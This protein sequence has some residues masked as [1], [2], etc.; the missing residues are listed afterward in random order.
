MRLTPADVHN[1]AFKKPSIGKRGYDEDEVDAF[2]DLVEAE[3]SRLIEE[4]NELTQR[5]AA[6]QA[7]G[8]AAGAPA[9]QAPYQQPEAV[10]QY[11]EQAPVEAE[12]DH[13]AA[14]A[15]APVAEAPA[16]VVAAEPGPA[17]HHMQAAKLLGIAQ[18]TAERLTNEAAADAEAQRAAAKA[19]S[20]KL[21]SDAQAEANR[22][23][24]EA[25]NKSEGM[26]NEATAKA[27]ALERDSRIRADAM[28]REAQG[29]YSQVMGQLTEQRTTLEKKIDDLRVYER[30]YRSRLKSWIT[31]QLSQLDEGGVA[32]NSEPA[33]QGAE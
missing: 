7:S 14:E 10:Q 28:D 6:A 27:E 31:D 25:Q 1:V 18:E 2:L 16:P 23:L 22:L 19:E 11:V 17:V 32:A 30:E 9:E 24:S 13:E 33:T 8:F 4:N 12:H 21:V 15:P 29:K 5:L 26:V 3:L 20:E